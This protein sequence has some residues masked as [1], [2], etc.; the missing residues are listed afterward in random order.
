MM[1]NEYIF[2]KMLKKIESW[3]N[4]ANPPCLFD[5]QKRMFRVVFEIKDGYMNS[6]FIAHIV[7]LVKFVVYL[8]NCVKSFLSISLYPFVGSIL[9]DGKR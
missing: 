7:G 1:R 2:G 6:L 4:R 9:V 5:I 8:F 3:P